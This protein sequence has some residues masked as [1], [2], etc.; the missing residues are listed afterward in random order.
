MG[1]VLMNKVDLKISCLKYFA[2]IANF[3]AQICLRVNGTHLFYMTYCVLHDYRSGGKR[4]ALFR[5]YHIARAREQNGKV[6]GYP[7]WLFVENETASDRVRLKKH[8]TC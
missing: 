4:P 5:E 8:T 6:H 3:S 2:E 7:P 1:L